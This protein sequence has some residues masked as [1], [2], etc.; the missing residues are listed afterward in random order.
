MQNIIICDSLSV[1]SVRSLN[2]F[3]LWTI[4]WSGVCVCYFW[5]FWQTMVYSR[6]FSNSKIQNV[7]TFFLSCFLKSMFCFH[8]VSPKKNCLHDSNL[9]RHIWISLP[10]LLLYQVQICSVISWL[11]VPSLLIA[12]A[13]LF[14]LKLVAVYIVINLVYI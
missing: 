9:C 4:F 2:R 3:V 6:I 1:L 10:S 13:H 14:I 12:S 8:K 5:V 11:L 7:L